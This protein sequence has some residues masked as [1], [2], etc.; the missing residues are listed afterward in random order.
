MY[1]N[2]L[3]TLIFRFKLLVPPSLFRLCHDD[4]R[5]GVKRGPIATDRST[6]SD[7]PRFV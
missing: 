7:H 4:R 5:H 2:V 1:F 6:M 3:H